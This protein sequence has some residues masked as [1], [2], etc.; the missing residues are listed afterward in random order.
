MGVLN[1]FNAYRL[2]G[3]LLI[4]AGIL[5]GIGASLPIFGEKGNWNIYTLPIQAQL[6]AIANNPNAWRWGN[7]FT[8]TAFVVLLAGLSLFTTILEEAKEQVFSR[9]GLVGLLLAAG[10]WVIFSAFRG[11]VG[12]WA[13]QE[14]AA[15]GTVPT[16]YEPLAKFAFV[17]FFTYAAIGF[18]AL[19]SYG[20]SLLRIEL[21]PAW[22]GWATLLFSVA[23]LALL[24]ITGDN[25]PLFHYIPPLLIGIL[26]L[27]HG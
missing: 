12:G 24:L 5:F 21:L 18:L 26:L 15:T 14:F 19:A 1:F 22:A 10:L 13:A 16:Y 4:V 2:T 7:I 25:L 23:M 8:G 6:Q 3:V 9:L 11:V 17:L 27:V 20:G